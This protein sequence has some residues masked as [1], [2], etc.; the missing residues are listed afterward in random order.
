MKILESLTSEG[1]RANVIGQRRVDS[2]RNLC[3]AIDIHLEFK[4]RIFGDRI[5]FSNNITC[6][7]FCPF[8]DEDAIN[9]VIDEQPK[10]VSEIEM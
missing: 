9:V 6:S 3:G 8:G 10:H 7:N 4:A 2:S 1:L 5:D